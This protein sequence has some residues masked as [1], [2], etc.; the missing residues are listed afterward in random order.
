M[1]LHT[2]Y[3]PHF[4][5]EKREMSACEMPVRFNDADRY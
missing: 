4:Q 3:F 2:H 5:E 1:Y